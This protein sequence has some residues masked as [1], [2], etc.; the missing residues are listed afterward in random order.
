MTRLSIVTVPDPILRK[1]S[2]PVEQVDEGV[3]RLLADMFESMIAGDGIGLAAIQV[4]IPK[5]LIVA[6]VAEGEEAP[7]ALKLVNPE[8]LWHSDEESIHEEGCLSL[9]DQLADVARP[10]RVR[11]RYVDENGELRELEA[12]GL[13]STCL[14]HE[15]DHLDGV[16]FTDHLSVVK[17]NI[18]IRKLKKAQRAK[19]ARL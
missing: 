19:A 2:A 7:T 13:L 4:G 12:Q 15:I 10:A 9:P 1:K 6:N 17:R 11:V 16:L 8:I 14:Q 5:R 18:I 3:R